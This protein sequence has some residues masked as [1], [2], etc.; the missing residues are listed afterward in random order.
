MT[1]GDRLRRW[2]TRRRPNPFFWRSAEKFTFRV[3]VSVLHPKRPPETLAL[4]LRSPAP[5]TLSNR[6]PAAPKRGYR[7]G[8][9]GE[10]TWTADPLQQLRGKAPGERGISYQLSDS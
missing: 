6:C 7:R 9:H 3:M 5:F 4:F 2:A 8:I 10:R 1:E